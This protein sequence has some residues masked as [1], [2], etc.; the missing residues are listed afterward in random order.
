MTQLLV[1][2]SLLAAPA[3]AKNPDCAPGT[4]CAVVTDIEDSVKSPA[5]PAKPVISWFSERFAAI[6]DSIARLERRF[7]PTLEEREAARFVHYMLAPDKLGGED[8]V[9]NQSDLDRVAEALLRDPAVQQQVRDGIREE[10]L[11]RASDSLPLLRG[12][13]SRVADRRTTPGTL[14]YALHYEAYWCEGLE[15]ARGRL[16]DELEAALTDGGVVAPET[17]EPSRLG[18]SLTLAEVER[19]QTSVRALLV[20]ADRAAGDI[21]VANT[22]EG[23]SQEFLDSVITL[24]GR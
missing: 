18:R 3:S 15:T 7:V 11:R 14:G 12:V 10:A 22:S 24:M 17:A 4:D 8:R 20:Y 1:L 23:L 21:T 2:V 9:F 5:P 13:A 16:V 6:S 19:F